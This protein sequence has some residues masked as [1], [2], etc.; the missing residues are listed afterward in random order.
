MNKKEFDFLL[1]EVVKNLDTL[2][3]EKR[4]HPD[5][6]DD[7]VMFNLDVVEFKIRTIRGGYL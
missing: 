4:K 2:S 7:E 6:I 3:K 5:Y 1:R